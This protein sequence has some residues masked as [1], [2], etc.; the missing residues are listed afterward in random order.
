MRKKYKIF[1][2]LSLIAVFWGCAYFNMYFNAKQSFNKAEEKR[3]ESNTI[4]RNLYEK[5]L[6]EL[7]KILEFYPD[8]KWV[9][10]ALLMMGLCYLRQEEY[11]KAQRKFS[12]LLS[13][14]PSSE[15]SDQAKIYLAEA[16][17]A[18]NNF[19][20]AKKLM[21]GIASDE[22]DIDEHE[23]IKLN[24]EMNLSTG[25]SLR[26]LELFIQSSEGIEGEAEK[27][28]LFER[29]ADIASQQK[30]HEISAKYYRKIIGLQE[31]REE[32]FDT[33][34]KYA[35]ALYN[36]GDTESAIEIL[37][38]ITKDPDYDDYSLKGKVVLAKYFLENKD[39]EE[40]EERID[41]ILKNNPKDR[42]N[43]K[44]LS[45]AAFYLGELNFNIT[46]D[47]E[48]AADMYDSSGYYDRRNEYYETA[49]E[50]LNLIR[51]VDILKKRLK[52]HKRSVKNT[53]DQIDSLVKTEEIKE[54]DNLVSL[55]E[56]LEQLKTSFVSAK[57]EL[58]EK[59]YF[60]MDLKDS[61]LVYYRDLSK[62]KLF[63][64]IASR[65][66]LRLVLADS[67][68]YSDMKDSLIALYPKT[69]AANFVR[70]QKGL[71]PVTIIQDSANYF[72]NAASQKFV[73]SLYSEAV[74]DY[75]DIAS[76]F[77]SSSSVPKILRAAGMTAEFKLKDN[78]KAK[79]IYTMLH[80]KYP[81]TEHGRFAKIKISDKDEIA[82][83]DISEQEDETDVMSDSDRWYMMDR[84][85]D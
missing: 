29:I 59:L 82:E 39:T 66:M 6:K 55:R 51:D 42:Y 46:K 10:D 4:D 22:V 31:S 76:R 24:A 69:Q 61:A 74:D 32:I 28:H 11:Y 50:R 72:F 63:P 3:K 56:N 53:E 25:D 41:K 30:E 79:E 13:N 85:N 1:I 78:E 83:Q 35:G 68:R 20:E 38:K 23:L 65:S 5:S 71:D 15:L 54:A 27:L 9:D 77:P 17:I 80:D 18:L 43:G 44:Y 67:S 12:E 45:E 19:E 60:E 33:T 16:E 47:F 36:A 58:A 21:S 2:F 8:S 70:R 40:V 81:D 52:D 73:D 49:S 62:E 64:H 75:L 37:E 48:K 7:S 34:V 84:R 26:A 57:H 14:F